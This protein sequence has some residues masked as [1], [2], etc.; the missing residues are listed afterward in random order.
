VH[1]GSTVVFGSMT[2]YGDRKS[3]FYDGYSYGLYGTP[4]SRALEAAIAALEGSSNSLVVPSGMAAITLVT[5][6]CVAQGRR[7]LFP[8]SIYDCGVQRPLR[9]RPRCRGGALDACTA[10]LPQR[11]AGERQPARARGDRTHAAVVRH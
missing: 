5:L 8:D 6:A 3:R 4:P 10:R 7:V 1:R 2:E 11:A 9:R